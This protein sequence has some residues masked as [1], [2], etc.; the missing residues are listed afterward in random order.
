MAGVPLDADGLVIDAARLTTRK[1]R[2][3]TSRNQQVARIDYEQDG[4]VA[5]AA[6][7]ALCAKLR[8]VAANAQAIVLS[9]YRKGAIVPAVIAA[10]AEAAR[11]AKVPLLVDPKVP[12]ADRYRGATLITPN[13]HEAE[14]MTQQSDA[15]DR[16]RAQRGA[17]AARDA[18]ARACSS[19][20]ASTACGC[21]TCRADRRSRRIC[22]RPR[23]RSRT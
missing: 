20:G 22:R 14:L 4:D 9:D 6:L 12:Q 11:A 23:A 21:S 18:A 19:R 13:H 15:I 16:R 17:A 3:V 7:E 2:V 1:L 10:A 5:G 8:A